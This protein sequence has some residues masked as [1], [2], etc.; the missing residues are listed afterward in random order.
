MYGTD[1]FISVARGCLG[2]RFPKKPPLII[3]YAF[4]STD[5]GIWTANTAQIQH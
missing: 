1:A 3:P 2:A 4:Y 5:S